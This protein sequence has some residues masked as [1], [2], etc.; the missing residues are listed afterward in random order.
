MA[1]AHVGTSTTLNSSS[2]TTVVVSVPGGT[3]N[4]HTLRAEITVIGQPTITAPGGWTLIGTQDAGTT[5]RVATYWRAAS[6]EPANYTW[7]LSSSFRAKGSITA[8]SGI[9]T[10]T[11]LDVTP[12]SNGSTTS[13]TSHGTP[14]ITPVTS[15]AWLETVVGARHGATGVATTWTISDGLDAERQDTGSANGSGSDVTG[16][17]YDSN[18][19][20][21]PGTYSRTVTASQ[22]ITQWAAWSIAWRPAV[23]GPTG[24]GATSAAGALTGTG[25]KSVSGAGVGVAVS[26]GSGTGGKGV[27]GSGLLTAVGDASS[28]G[29]KVTGTGYYYRPRQRWQLVAGPA[30]GGH[31]LSL[32]DAKDKRLVFRLTEPSE[33]S[34]S[35][36]ARNFQASAIEELRTDV[37]VLYTTDVGVTEILARG[38]VGNTGDQLDADAHRV[39]VT[40]LDYRAVLQR[41]ILY[42][43][44]T[45]TWTAT[46][47]SLIAWNLISQTQAR[48]GGHLGISRG[49]GQTTGVTR[50]RTYEAGDSIGQRVQELSEVI[51]GFDW[52]ITSSSSSGL[53]LN[54]WFPERG[55]D[56]GV[57][58]EYGGLAASIRRDVNVS[59]Y[60]N[61]LRYTGQA[62]L[63]G[64]G[65]GPTAQ[66]LESADLA[67]RPEGRWDIALGNDS[68]ALQATLN[69]RALWQLGQSEV[70]QPTYSVTLRQGAWEGPDHIWLGDSVLL[71]IYSGRLAINSILRVF[72]I[73][74]ALEDDG[75]EKVEVTLGGPKPDFR[76][77]P[78]AID[79]RLSELERR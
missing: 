42:G 72:E 66:E 36:D 40:C 21:T 58:L 48:T 55:E 23:T 3:V 32:T 18:R 76:R 16:A 69:E 12:T 75:T 29:E 8:R 60:A 7:T 47:Q 26:G 63:E 24:T 2:A 68:I 35:M 5:L 9:D 25:A 73:Q 50:D 51:D 71:V 17:V 38:R 41:R 39:A 78:A 79:R 77:W 33:I 57:V 31:E 27:A 52:D 74:I 28:S 56:R 37:H 11:P 64:G 59:D 54:I 70:I 22:T 20:L 13:G 30:A 49:I 19:T 65:P 62:E 14:S 61:A 4:G 43:T 44:S 15:G 10:T 34:F 67:S 1:I 53:H 45:L 6:S 46:D